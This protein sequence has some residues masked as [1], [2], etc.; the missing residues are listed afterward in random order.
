M[1]NN[2]FFNYSKNNFVRNRNNYHN[3]NNFPRNNYTSNTFSR[4]RDN[5]FTN[6][7]NFTSNRNIYSNKNRYNNSLGQQ[8]RRLWDSYCTLWIYTCSACTVRARLLSLNGTADKQNV[9][10][11][12]SVLALALVYRYLFR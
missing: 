10:Y 1:N 4:N 12:R 6:N 5:N 9:N 11:T 7:N 8:P 3:D 2:F